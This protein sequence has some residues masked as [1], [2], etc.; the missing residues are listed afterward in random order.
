MIAIKAHYDG[1]YLVP[2][3]PLHVPANKPLRV[4]VEVVEP[5]PVGAKRSILA[6]EGLGAEIWQGI[7]AQTYVDALRA[8]WDRHGQ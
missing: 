4:Q 3:E 5:V 6:L 1:K 2:E 8:E 7:D